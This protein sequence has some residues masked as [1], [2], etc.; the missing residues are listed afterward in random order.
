MRR[1][2]T[3]RDTTNLTDLRVGLYVRVSL[4]QD[5]SGKSTDD[6]EAVGREWVG[7][8]GAVLVD[9]YSD[10]DRSASRYATKEREE[11]TRLLGDIEAGKLDAV[12]FWELSR[13]QRRLDVF[14]KLRDLCRGM[15]VLWVIRDRVYDPSAYADMMTLGMLSV[16]GENE[17]EMT[18][19]RVQ[20]GKKSS[21]ATGR[22]AGK[23]PY[24]YRAVY[25]RDGRYI[26]DEPD[27][28]D[29]HGLP[30]EDSPAYIVRE[31]YSRILAGHSLTSIR[32]DLND[33]GV[34]TRGGYSWANS[35]VRFIAMSPTYL[36]QRVYQVGDGIL[37]ADRA[38][39][40]LD[41][42]E[43]KWPP[44]VD[45]E[46]FWAVHRLLSDPARKKT[47]SGPRTGIYLL[48]SVAWCGECGG[49]LLRKKFPPNGN[50]VAPLPDSY[51]CKDRS[52]VGIPAEMLDAY[53]ETVMVRWLSDPAVVADLTRAEDSA[54][55]AQARGDVEQLRAELAALYRDAKAGR[56]SPV[57]ATAT[58]TGLKERIDEAEQRVQAATL[59][60]V[61]RGNIG[62]QAEAGWAALDME[63]KRQMIRVVADI[64]VRKVGRGHHNG[65]RGPVPARDRVEWRW[66]LGPA[67]EPAEGV[68]QHLA[69]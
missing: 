27:L 1:R 44:L 32:R 29:G 69:T 26:H 14:A 47:R 15:G 42:V 58:E 18:S 12:W 65:H 5:D 22:R 60:P 67:V 2:P 45:A 7:K 30:V 41:G 38:K 9:V 68:E 48:S 66:L 28:F 54:A 10:R 31:I 8:V 43:T 52:C 4:D 46:T 61:L 6:Q 50:R 35:T 19:E 23:V 11:F 36:G 57:I 34:R 33:R 17:S 16:I 49:K 37:Q 59:P 62:P 3:K 20:R 56:V 39:M 25:D 13:S 51:F 24:G 64:R 21:A 55:A 40:V 53:A 63:V